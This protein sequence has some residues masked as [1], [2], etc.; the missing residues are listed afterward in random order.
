MIDIKLLRE[1]PDIFKKACKNKNATID[2]DEILRL[3]KKNRFLQQKLQ[4]SQSEIN[5][6]SK[7]QPSLQ[8][9]SEL[10]GQKEEIK[11]LEAEQ[12]NLQEKLTE[13]LYKIPNIPSDD[14]PIGK[15]ASAN[16]VMCEKGEKPKFSFPPREH[17]ELG[18]KLG[19]L[20]MERATRVSGARF[21]YLLG[22]L[23]LMQFAIIQHTLSIVTQEAIL[24]KIIQ[25]AKLNVS[26]KPF[27]PVIPPVFI[28]PDVYQRMARLEPKEERY[29]IPSD[30]VY[31]V[32]SAEHTLGPYLLGETL[33]E[34]DLPMRFI[35]YSSSFRREAGSYGKDMKGIIRVHQFD[36]LEMESFTSAQHSVQEQDFIVSVQEYLVQSLKLPYR[37]VKISAGDMGGPD[38]RQIDIETWM[39]GQGQ[40][41]E[42]HTSDLNTDY[43]ARRLKIKI[44]KKNGSQE[45]AHM[46]DATA[47]AIG[48]ILVAIMEN[49]QN[50]N[51]TIGIPSV[52]QKYMHGKK[53]INGV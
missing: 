12:K 7:T 39:P 46:N 25:A 53:I 17:W 48:R 41:R 34:N 11:K 47:F 9:I 18:D 13:L 24:K 45:Y 49:Y 15:D 6:K 20:N 32:G 14:T 22:D 42:T 30:D 51:G 52:L 21:A 31:L 23:A 8:G 2:I 29:Y 33:S 16:V 38:A 36:K 19:I 3:D 44:K 26:P 4:E 1:Q 28:R 27:V 35:G 50:K 40:Y 5:K 37:V 43:Q 10:R